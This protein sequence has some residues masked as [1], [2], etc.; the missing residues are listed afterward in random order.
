MRLIVTVD[1]GITALE[2]A[3]LC[4]ELGVTLVVTDH[5]ECKE[6][7]PQC[8]AVVDPHRPDRT[9]P[10][11]MLSGVGIAFKLAAALSGDQDGVAGAIAISS[12]SARLQTL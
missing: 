12:A 7:L 2:E 8:A 10:H 4:R 3:G 5:H 6:Q 11:T 1:C 9:Y